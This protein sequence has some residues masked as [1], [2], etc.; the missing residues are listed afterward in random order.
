MTNEERDS[1]K[2]ALYIIADIIAKNDYNVPHGVVK[3]N[4]VG[5]KKDIMLLLNRKNA[6]IDNK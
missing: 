2:Q 6:S 3:N 4:S 5:F 1:L